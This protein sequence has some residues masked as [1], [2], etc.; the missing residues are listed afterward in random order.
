MI[1]A[2]YIGVHG[3][4]AE[5]CI[6]RTCSKCRYDHTGIQSAVALAR[7]MCWHS[8][9]RMVEDGLPE[10]C[11]GQ[12]MQGALGAIPFQFTTDI[13]GMEGVEIIWWCRVQNIQL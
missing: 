11:G 12:L 10:G 5:R 8:I 3:I 7:V 4:H 6:L 13:S 9:V 2:V 1:Y